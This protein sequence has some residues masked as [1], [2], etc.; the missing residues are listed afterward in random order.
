MGRQFQTQLDLYVAFIAG[1]D[2]KKRYNKR[3]GFVSTLEG[4][5]RLALTAS[6]Y[7]QRHFNDFFFT[8]EEKH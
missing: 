5:K 3:F 7:V 8:L 2:Q 1:A 4:I 6:T